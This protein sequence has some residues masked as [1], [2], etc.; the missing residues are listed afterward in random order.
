[1]ARLYSLLISL[2]ALASLGLTL[3]VGPRNT[4][5][6][7]ITLFTIW[8]LSPFGALALANLSLA[9]RSYPLIRILTLLIPLASVTVYSIVAVSQP[10]KPAFWFLVVPLLS[11]LLIAMA[12]LLAA[13]AAR[14]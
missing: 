14:L 7:L 4:S 1:M 3:Y 10:D 12:G 8:V 13:R 6:F 9:F 5:I 11:W 2:T